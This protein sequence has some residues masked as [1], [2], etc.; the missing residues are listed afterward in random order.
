MQRFTSFFKS[1]IG[2]KVVMGVTG[3]LFATFLIAHVAGNMLL[4]VSPELFN[5]YAYALTSNKALLYTAEAGLVGILVAHIVSAAILSKRNRAA[6]PQSYAK[7][8]NSGRSRRRWWSS[9]MG[10]SGLFILFFIVVHLLNFKWGPYFTTVVDDTEMRDLAKLVISD[11]QQPV[12]VAFYSIAMVL[13]AMHL[14]HGVRSAFAT[15][16]LE[17]PR[18]ERPL[19][20]IARF[21]AVGVMGLFLLIPLWIYFIG[22]PQ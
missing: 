3:I 14:M 20:F 9:N 6:R 13:I 15:L 5:K 21:W 12:K 16:G 17:S 8:Q 7:K 19:Y 18:Y 1:N 4:L 22:V 2:L 11:F 10:I